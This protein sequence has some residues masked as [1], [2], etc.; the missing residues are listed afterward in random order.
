MALALATTKRS[1]EQG[2]E[3][4]HFRIIVAHEK[5]D[6]K[7]ECHYCEHQMVAG[8]TRMR[9]HLLKHRGI[10]CAPC[11]GEVPDAVQKEMQ[12]VEDAAQATKKQ[13]QQAAAVDAATRRSTASGAASTSR[14][15]SGRRALALDPTATQLDPAR[16]TGWGGEWSDERQEGSF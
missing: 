9:A 7:V 3:H 8:A 16:S 13:K 15:S 14:Q 1:A 12:Q 4:K 11:K 2:P 10:G 5:G 6:D